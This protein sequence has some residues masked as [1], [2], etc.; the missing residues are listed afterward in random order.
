[1]LLLFLKLVMDFKDFKEKLKEISSNYNFVFEEEFF[2][3]KY[4]VGKEDKPE[5]YIKKENFENK[6][7]SLKQKYENENFFSLDAGSSIIFNDS[8]KLLGLIKIVF[9]KF[10]PVTFKKKFF[11]QHFI[12]DVEVEDEN[13]VVNLRK[14]YDGKNS[15]SESNV[16]S[17]FFN[18]NVENVSFKTPI[19]STSIHNNNNI[20]VLK[21]IVDTVD[22]ARSYIEKLFL[23]EFVKNNLEKKFFLFYDGSLKEN[24]VEEKIFLEEIKILQ[25]NNNNFLIVGFCKTSNLLS[26]NFSPE[27]KLFYKFKDFD[28]WFY[29]LKEKEETKNRKNNNDFFVSFTKLHSKSNYVFRIDSFNNDFNTIFE[30]LLLHSKDPAFF[31]YPYILILND[32]FARITNIENS[33]YK[34]LLSSFFKKNFLKK[35]PHNVLDTLEF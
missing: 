32:K 14:F 13:F 34:V 9:L 20:V 17:D 15:N 24:F 19:Y 30:I 28:V 33:R 22:I 1:M 10:N 6:I 26:N 8:S 35:S 2:I 21:N 3:H 27:E 7:F 23:K 29:N 25:K 12:L 4:F 5:F 16:D 31:G 11:I 18:F